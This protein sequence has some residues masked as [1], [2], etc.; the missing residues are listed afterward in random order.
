[1]KNFKLNTCPVCSTNKIKD[2]YK[3]KYYSNKVLE[4]LKINTPYPDVSIMVCDLCDHSYANPILNEKSLDKYYSQCNSHFYELS[5]IPKSDEL[6]DEHKFI[7]EV[8]SRA[9]KFKVGKILEI[10]CGYG[11]LL[12]KFKDAKWDTYGIEPSPYASKVAKSVNEINVSNN[13]IENSGYENNSFDVVM[14]FDVMEHLSDAKLM[15]N[16]IN[17][18]LKKDGL[19]IFGTGNINS[20]NAKLNGKSWSYFS[21]WEHISFFNEKSSKYLMKKN[22]FEML[23]LIRVSHRNTFLGNSL[24]LA[25]NIFI[26]KPF[27]IIIPILK[28]LPIIKNKFSHKNFIKNGVSFS[29]LCF[30]HMLVLAKRI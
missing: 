8:I 22:G 4:I 15:V 18:L 13:Y 29:E 3:I 6:E 17:K 5:K 19:L 24:K 12:K 20:S 2:R 21:T 28:K 30:D 26:Y 25:S 14:L 10:G 23:E 16:N 27:N 11:Y 1:M 7:F 9:A